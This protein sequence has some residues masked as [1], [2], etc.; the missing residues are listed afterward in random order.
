MRPRRRQWLRKPQAEISV[1]AAHREED[2]TS[3]LERRTSGRARQ[4]RL[5]FGTQTGLLPACKLD[6]LAPL[7]G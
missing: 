4:R 1:R 2:R 5:W 3:V 7:L 6:I